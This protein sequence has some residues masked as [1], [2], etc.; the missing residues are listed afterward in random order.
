MLVKRSD[1][2][3]NYTIPVIINNFRTIWYYDCESDCF[4]AYWQ[5][6]KING[7]IKPLYPVIY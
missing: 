3:T 1:K 2:I 7:V 4:K 6:K 5:L